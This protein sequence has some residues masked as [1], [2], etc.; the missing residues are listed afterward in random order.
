MGEFT[1]PIEELGQ[2]ASEYIDLHL[3]E[4]KLTTATGLSVTLSKLR[5]TKS[6]LC[7]D[8]GAGTGSVSLEMAEV[9]TDGMVYA[10]ER[11]D[12]ACDLIDQNKRHLGVANVQVVRGTAP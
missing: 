1:R 10:E 5:L 4:L 7:W 2:E 3:D 8:V 12:E 11:K 9:C 6:A